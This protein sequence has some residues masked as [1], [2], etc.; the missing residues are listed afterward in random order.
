MLDPRKMASVNG[1]RERVCTRTWLFSLQLSV[2][3]RA[4]Q[5]ILSS[6]DFSQPHVALHLPEPGQVTEKK[7]F[8]IGLNEGS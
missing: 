2:E 3:S 4:T 1:N 6:N 8:C 7:H 5:P